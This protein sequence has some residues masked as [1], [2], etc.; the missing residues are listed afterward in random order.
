MGKRS[1]KR[2]RDYS[3]RANRHLAAK[4]KGHRKQEVR[5]L[6]NVPPNAVANGA[7]GANADTTANS[8]PILAY[9]KQI[10]KAV[11][12]NPTIILVGETGSGKTTQTPQYCTRKVLQVKI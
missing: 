5:H 9:R 1:K 7:S 12:K 8:L 10:L 6:D 3:N 11:R 4:H 2:K